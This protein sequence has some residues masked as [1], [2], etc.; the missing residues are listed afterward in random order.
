MK[1][2]LQP[3]YHPNRAGVCDRVSSDS[4]ELFGDVIAEYSGEMHG[5][6]AI[7]SAKTAVGPYARI[8]VFYFFLP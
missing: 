4:K 2:L 8:R 3:C 5:Q 6:A 7:P 1:H